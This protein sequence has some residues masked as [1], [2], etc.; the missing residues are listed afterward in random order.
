MQ[1]IRLLQRSNVMKAS[2]LGVVSLVVAW[3]AAAR[4]ADG[5]AAATKQGTQLSAT[6]AQGAA[7]QPAT[8]VRATTVKANPAI[9]QAMP[10]ATVAQLQL[11][12]VR[13]E[14]VR[15][16][17]VNSNAKA[18]TATASTGG[19]TVEVKRG[20]L[21]ILKKALTAAP[22][23]TPTALAEK[24][25]TPLPATLV[26]GVAD[27]VKGT[28]ARQFQPFLSAE[29]SPLRWDAQAAS[30][31]TT[32]VVGLDPLPG[33][34]DGAVT[35]PSAIRFQLSGE[36]VTSIDP[37]NVD[38]SVAGTTGYQR[39]RV[40]TTR[41]DQAIKVNAH[42]RFGDKSY[43]AS[44]DPG[45]ARLE[46]GR[47]D[48]R[49]D[50][51]GLGKTT[52]S[53]RQLAANRQ[54]WP[55]LQAQRIQLETTSGYLTPA[56]VQITAQSATGET[57]LV[58]QGWGEA[59]VGQRNADGETSKAVVVFAFPWLKFML[60][61]FGAAVA[62]ALRVFTSEPGKRQGWGPVFVG[63]LASGIVIDILVALGAPLAPEWLLGMMRS[64]LAWLAIGLVAG[65]P[66]VALVAA[67]GDKIFGVKKPEPASASAS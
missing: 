19:S 56:S 63:C 34:D 57:A 3:G 24:V 13:P 38:V 45:P 39:F 27:P 55:A 21:L 2:W 41:F 4:A 20:E 60:G 53:V 23:A 44:V 25:K 42:S 64:E 6:K 66:G 46:I 65:Y 49:V 5:S 61:F 54:E 28:V 50:G 1:P 43:G 48:A 47:S 9:V 31:L 18:P 29:V 58:S 36:N 17:A 12:T 7:V 8:P 30:Y 67:L 15:I 22:S 16:E 35:L 51:F 40:L 33:D 59:I 37:L 52:I 26:V 10:Q 62:G 14:L 32:V 11:P